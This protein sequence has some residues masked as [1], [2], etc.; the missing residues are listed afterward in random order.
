MMLILML[1]RNYYPK[2][3]L[4]GI[5]NKQIRAVMVRICLSWLLLLDLNFK[6]NF[7]QFCLTLRDPAYNKALRDIS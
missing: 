3:R 2:V 1:N 7:K 4:S 5:K 6:F